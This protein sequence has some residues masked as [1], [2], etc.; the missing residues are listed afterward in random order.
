MS[1]GLTWVV[2][3]DVDAPPVSPTIEIIQYF[4]D[5]NE[6]SAFCDWYLRATNNFVGPASFGCY[7]YTTGPNDNGLWFWNGA[8]QQTVFAAFD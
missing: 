4:N 1:T 2:M 8:T 6:A 3:A 7:I 5:Y